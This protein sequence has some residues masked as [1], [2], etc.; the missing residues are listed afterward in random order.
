MSTYTVVLDDKEEPLQQETAWHIF[1]SAADAQSWWREFSA[2]WDARQDAPDGWVM[3][4]KVADP[5]D[6]GWLTKIV[7]HS[8]IMGAIRRIISGEVSENITGACRRT[9]RD[10]VFNRAATDFDTNT[11]DE[12]LQ[13]AVLGKIV[14][15]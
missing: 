4:V 15:G 6:S 9:C 8:M 2:S 12:V 1:G 13:V 5:D 3:T 10:F 14:Y 11:A 7:T